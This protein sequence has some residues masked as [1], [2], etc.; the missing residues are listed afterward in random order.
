MTL[1]SQ[2]WDGILEEWLANDRDVLWRRYMDALHSSLFAGW[3][4]A[5]HAERLLK[6]DLFDE[7]VSE[8]L[9]ALAVKAELA[10]GID[11]STR[12]AE[13]ARRRHPVWIAVVADVRRLPFADGA[14][15]TILSNSTLDHFD[16]VHEI[17]LALSELHRVLRPGGHLLLTLDNAANPIVALRQ[18]LPGGFWRRLGLVPYV[19]GAT[20]GPRRLRQMMASLSLR[21]VKMRSFLHVP[22]FWAV[23]CARRLNQAPNTQQRRFLNHLRRWERLTDLPS[24]WLTG[25]FIA[26]LATKE[27]D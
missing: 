19:T 21:V 24:R 14:F 5:A 15:D 18:A 16:S 23:R 27:G 17:A 26:L 25:Y 3:L 4:C 12:V 7:A 11:L 6:T 2:Y 8:G 20:V 9:E 13:V 10:V 22:R 1:T